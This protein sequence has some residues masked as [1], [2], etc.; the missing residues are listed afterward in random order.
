[1]KAAVHIIECLGLQE[2]GPING[3]MEEQQKEK[4][5]FEGR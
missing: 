5:I 4:G 2:T 3:T 1:M